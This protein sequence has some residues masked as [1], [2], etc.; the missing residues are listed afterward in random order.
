M[1]CEE[2]D[3][4]WDDPEP[5]VEVKQINIE[6]MTISKS[7]LLTIEIALILCLDRKLERLNLF[8]PYLK[9]NRAVAGIQ[10]IVSISENG[11]GSSLQDLKNA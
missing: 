5:I 4:W 10:L 8:L 3:D 2:D 9:V 7:E 1:S 6:N 11:G